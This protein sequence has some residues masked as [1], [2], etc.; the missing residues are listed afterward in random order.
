[1]SIFVKDGVWIEDPFK[2]GLLAN[3]PEQMEIGQ[4]LRLKLLFTC[5]SGPLLLARNALSLM[6]LCRADARTGYL[7]SL[8]ADTFNPYPACRRV[9]VELMKSLMFDIVNQA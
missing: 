8:V 9:F 5:G 4:H 1:L 6:L 2:G 7:V 3:F